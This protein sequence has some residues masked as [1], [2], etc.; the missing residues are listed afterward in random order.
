MCGCKSVTR[1]CE[2]CSQKNAEYVKNSLY[3]QSKKAKAG[4]YG[5]LKQIMELI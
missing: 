2:E 3:L 1:R 5:S 4:A